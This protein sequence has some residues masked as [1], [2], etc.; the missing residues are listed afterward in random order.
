M[1]RIFIYDELTGEFSVNQAELKLIT[2]F[3]DLWTEAKLNCGCERDENGVLIGNADAISRYSNY[4]KFVYLY[5]DAASPYRDFTDEERRN[6]AGVD[7]ML[8]GK[9]IEMEE[10]WKAC[11]KW[12]EIQDKDRN[13]RLLHSAQNRVDDMIS[14]FSMPREVGKGYS[15]KEINDSIKAIDDIGNASDMLDRFEDRVKL[16]E[17]TSANIRSDAVEGFIVDFEKEKIIRQGK[18]KADAKR[19]EMNKRK[20]EYSETAEPVDVPKKKGRPRKTARKT[21]DGD[22][23]EWRLNLA[24]EM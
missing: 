10:L 22:D 5:A 11:A 15:I 9:E 6:S 16:G 7:A 19:I 2:E 14:Y 17:S 13:I 1:Q 20:K 4:C 8:T 24:L 21:T 3:S 18:M 12:V 23:D